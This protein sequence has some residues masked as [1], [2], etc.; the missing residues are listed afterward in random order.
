MATVRAPLRFGQYIQLSLVNLGWGPG[1]ASR[2][3]LEK[4]DGE[5]TKF[6]EPM[7]T[8][9]FPMSDGFTSAPRSA[10]LQTSLLSWE[11]WPAREDSVGSWNQRCTS[12]SLTVPWWFPAMRFN[13]A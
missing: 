4:A 12:Q 1:G 13:F 11:E 2:H 5:R 7:E 9:D 3:F 8:H 6:S 10:G